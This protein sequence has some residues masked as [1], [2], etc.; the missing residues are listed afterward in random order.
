MSWRE[1]KTE[2]NLGK[3]AP[4]GTS[5]T[6]GEFN[7]DSLIHVVLPVKQYHVMWRLYEKWKQE[8]G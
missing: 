5:G 4:V 2:D 1:Q 7:E 3:V 6:S 8:N